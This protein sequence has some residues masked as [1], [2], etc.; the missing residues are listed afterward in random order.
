MVETV[1]LCGRI[2]ATESNF[3]GEK[4]RKSTNFIVVPIGSLLIA[5][6]IVALLTDNCA[7]TID[8]SNF[9]YE[10]FEFFRYQKQFANGEYKKVKAPPSSLSSHFDRTLAGTD[11]FLPPA[12]WK[13]CLTNFF[14]F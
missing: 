6:L 13:L 9:H 1:P 8:L 5:I 12:K 3:K 11:V 2:L 7:A 10:N 14:G 4:M